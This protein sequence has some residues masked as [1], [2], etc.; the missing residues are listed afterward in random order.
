MKQFCSYQLQDDATLIVLSALTHAPLFLF[1]WAKPVPVVIRNLR[2][3]GKVILYVSHRMDEIYAAE[4][5][6]LPPKAA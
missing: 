1:G 3:Q 2:Q 5:P 4:L 6:N